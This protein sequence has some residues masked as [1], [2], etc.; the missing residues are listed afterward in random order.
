MRRAEELA[1]DETHQDAQLANSQATST[2]LVTSSDHELVTSHNLLSIERE[3]VATSSRDANSSKL[4]DDED[5]FEDDDR[6][7]TENIAETEIESA[8]PP[9]AASSGAAGGWPLDWTLLRAEYARGNMAAINV[10]C[11]IRRVKVDDVLARLDAE[12]GHVPQDV[13]DD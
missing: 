11:G 12:A 1:T 2:E 4:E 9:A 8:P 10:H 5:L 7:T 13:D 6:Q 3:Q